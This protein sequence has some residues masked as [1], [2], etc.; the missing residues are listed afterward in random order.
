[1]SILNINDDSTWL[2]IWRE[3][4]CITSVAFLPKVCKQNMI[5]KRCQTKT[6]CSTFHTHTQ[7]DLI[8]KKFNAIKYKKTQEM[9]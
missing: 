5:M 1:M 7:M 9:F 6:N 3:D 2:L 8:Q 4:F